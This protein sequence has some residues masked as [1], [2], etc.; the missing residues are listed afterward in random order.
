MVYRL[1]INAILVNLLD[2]NAALVPNIIE[3]EDDI[4]KM[5][6]NSSNT[7][8]DQELKDSKNLNR[9]SSNST[10]PSVVRVI[11]KVVVKVKSESGAIKVEPKSSDDDK[12]DSKIFMENGMFYFV[13]Y[14]VKET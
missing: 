5:L 14:F 4:L 11:P 8:S 3:G 2:F 12:K 10:S 13:L 1:L 7:V 9:N 6:L